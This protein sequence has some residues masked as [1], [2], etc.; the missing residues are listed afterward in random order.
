MT[1][2]ERREPSHNLDQMIR[3]FREMEDTQAV[4]LGRLLSPS[5]KE[6]EQSIAP[7]PWTALVQRVMTELAATGKRSEK[8]R[9]VDWL[10]ALR[11]ALVRAEFQLTPQTDLQAASIALLQLLSHG[12]VSTISRYRYYVVL[13]HLL[14]NG[15]MDWAHSEESKYAI[16]LLSIWKQVGAVLE[17][18]PP[19]QELQPANWPHWR[20]LTAQQWLATDCPH[21]FDLI[22]ARRAEAP[23]A[24]QSV[25]DPYASGELPSCLY[26]IDWGRKDRTPC[27]CI[28]TQPP[29]WQ[30]IPGGI[31]LIAP[32][33]RTFLQLSR[34]WTEPHLTVRHASGSAKDPIDALATEFKETFYLLQ[35][36]KDSEWALQSGQ[37]AD[38]SEP[39]AWKKQFL[40]ILRDE[41]QF[42]LSL[43]D[44]LASWLP[45]LLD[46]LQTQFFKG[47]SQLTQTERRQLIE[48]TH[49]HLLQLTIAAL[50][51]VTWNAQGRTRL[52]GGQMTHQLHA[53]HNLALTGAINDPSWGDILEAITWGPYL[54][55]STLL[56]PSPEEHQLTNSV[57]QLL[58]QHAAALPTLWKQLAKQWGDPLLTP[59]SITPFENP[60]S[61]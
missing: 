17:L 47:Q 8:Q 5:D 37:W 57:A 13:C 10:L 46:A 28:C 40:S 16:T 4:A 33:F 48:L 29:I 38:L 49:L 60:W 23:P 12:F 41:Y 52:D 2:P 58:T 22:Q 25:L 42:P 53:L 43:R 59:L 61:T 9:Y 55:S 34:V 35:L 27:R 56:P 21:L 24:N 15:T 31:R 32:E 44:K 19:E 39:T 7:P 30:A 14:R 1:T 51:P 11:A 18:I 20:Q 36:P 54:E 3:A 50:Q 45:N 6:G 26:S